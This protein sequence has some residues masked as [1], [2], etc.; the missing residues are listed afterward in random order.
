STRQLHLLVYLTVQFAVFGLL[1][2]ASPPLDAGTTKLLLCPTLVVDP[3]TGVVYSFLRKISTAPFKMLS[4]AEEGPAP[5]STTKDAPQGSAVRSASA[6]VHADEEGSPEAPT[7]VRLKSAPLQEGAA[8]AEDQVS[9]HS[10]SEGGSAS[11]AVPEKLEEEMSE[12]SLQGDPLQPQIAQAFQ[13]SELELL[14]KAL[15]MP[16]REASQASIPSP[17]QDSGGGGDAGAGGSEHAGVGDDGFQ[18]S[19]ATAQLFLSY[20]SA[21]FLALRSGVS[22]AAKSGK[23]QDLPVWAEPP[24]MPNIAAPQAL[25]LPRRSLSLNVLDGYD[26]LKVALRLLL[27]TVG[28]QEASQKLMEVPAVQELSIC[29]HVGL[30]HT[31]RRRDL[32]ERTLKLTIAAIFQVGATFL[33]LTADGG[34]VVSAGWP[35]RLIEALLARSDAEPQLLVPSAR[36]CVEAVRN[37]VIETSSHRSLCLPDLWRALL[38]LLLRAAPTSS[39]A[40]WP[41]AKDKEV[42]T[43]QLL[44]WRRG[45]VWLL[46]HPQLHDGDAAGEEGAGSPSDSEANSFWGWVLSELTTLAQEMAGNRGAG[47][48]RLLLYAYRTLLRN[49]ARPQTAAE[50]ARDEP[51]DLQEDCSGDAAAVT[52]ASPCANDQD[53]DRAAKAAAWSR[54]AVAMVNFVGPAVGRPNTEEPDLQVLPLLKQSLLHARVP[55]LLAAGNH[56]PFWARSVLEK[57]VSVLTGPV[58]SGAPLTVVR[59]AVSLVSKFFLQNLQ[60][61]QRHESFGQLWLM[62]L[63]LMLQFIKRGSDDRDA[64]LE[65][66]STE[67]LKN[68]LGVLVSTNVLGFV[69]PKAAQPNDTASRPVWWQMT[70]D[71]IEVFIPGFG[72]DFSR[73]VLGTST[74]EVQPPGQDA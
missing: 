32:S 31:I 1:E 51:N 15:V 33:T 53:L 3:P 26:T 18:A 44:V 42:E 12:G 67:T 64:E 70:W 55:S 43:V 57:L 9:D 13:A 41:S 40:L 8:V 27:A 19:S 69:S 56:G 5:T 65:E 61:L 39:R 52:G 48:I 72:E 34:P 4:F 35:V 25:L 22:S 58:T 49:L 37:F 20:L 63:R 10:Q 14:L 54:V 36:L 7:P 38:Q 59:E 71:C 2:R 50:Y 23:D 74:A 62:V 28:Q 6:P 47:S 16:W 29:T 24:S 73:S 46:A 66:V 11:P 21:L 68:L 30:Y 45:L 17:R 60:T